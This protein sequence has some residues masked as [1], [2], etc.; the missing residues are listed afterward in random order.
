MSQTSVFFGSVN[1]LLGEAVAL[2]VSDIHLTPGRPVRFRCDGQ[3]RPVP[4]FPIPDPTDTA[5]FAARILYQAQKGDRENV[6]KRVQS[7][8]DEDCS[9]SLPR[10]GRFRVNICRQ[11]G[12]LELVLRVVSDKVPT[13]D[14]LGLPEVLKQIAMEERGLVL[15]T[16]ITGS[17]KSTT[18]A[19]MIHEVNQHHE[20]KIVTIED[21]IEYLHRDIR[22][23]I[24]QREVGTDT[25]SFSRA[26]RAA[27][28]Q[29]PD[30]IMVGE[31]R[32]RETIDVGLKA[33]ETGHLV[34]TTVHTTDAAKTVHRILSV[35]DQAEQSALRTRLADALKATIAQRLLRRLDGKGRVAAMEI[36][37]MTLAIRSCIE[38]GKDGIDEFIAKGGDHYG[39]QTFDQHLIRLYS[40]GLISLQVA[41]TAATSPSDLEHA[42]RFT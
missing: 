4:G 37:R 26:L 28:R 6:M 16:G 13:L 17:G 12:A 23:V 35:F 7:I 30:I 42:L 2:G 24:T 27:L 31:M 10:I 9:L 21:P 14:T 25:P 20:K 32:D 1:E 22:S 38:A 11:R 33:A 5:S 39:M 36:M 29:D 40:A 19:A 15:V 34:F 8:Q 3:I 41:K 18:L